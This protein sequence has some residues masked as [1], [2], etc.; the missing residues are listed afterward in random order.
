VFQDFLGPLKC[1]DFRLFILGH[2]LSFTGSWIQ[3]TALHWLIYSLKHSTSQLGLYTFLTTFPGILITFLSGFLID[4]FDRK[5]LLQLLL[6]SALFPPL[7]MGIL[8]YQGWVNFWVF[9]LLGFLASS[10]AS[11]DMPLRQ[12]FISEIVPP[13]YLTRALSLQALSF[14]AAR[15]FGPALAGLILTFFHLSLCFFIN[16]LSFLPLSIFTFF[17]RGYPRERGKEEQRPLLEEWRSFK[18][19]LKENPQILK[20]TLITGIF[21]FFGVSVIILFPMLATKVLKGSAKDYAFLASGLG[22]G[23]IFGAISVFFRGEIKSKALQLRLAHLIWGVAILGLMLGKG[24]Y[25]LFLSA[26]LLGS[27]FTNFYPIANSYLQEHSPRELRGKVMSLFSIAFLGMAPLGQMF[28]GFMIEWLDYRVFL[29]GILVLL[30][31]VNLKLL[32]SL[33]EGSPLKDS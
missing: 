13:R 29:A 3:N 15:M 6:F 20:V 17:I 21:T 31:S 18:G 30:L 9:V 7:V 10:L 4:K 11:M 16:F 2:F 26:L 22:F 14:N 12:V 23:A 8:A 19:F 1:K 33:R 24:F 27:S 5:R 32:T 28:T 25:L